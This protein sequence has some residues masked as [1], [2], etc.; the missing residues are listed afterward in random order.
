MISIQNLT[1]T[2]PNQSLPAIENIC[3]SVLDG[4]FV[5]V[6]GPSGSGKSTLLRTINGLVP[7]FSGGQI[8]GK[9]HVH[10][11]DVVHHGPQ[12]MSRYVGFVG[13]DPESQSVLD[14]VESEIAF[15]LENQ[16]VPV[17]EMRLRVEEVL[18]LL[19]LSPLR[20]RSITNLSGGE[21]QRVAIAVALAL[22]PS[23]LV[24]DEPTSQLDPQSAEDVLR[25]LVR[26]NEDL[27]LTIVLAEHRLERIIRYVD[28]ITHMEDGRIR[29]DA[30][31]Q[32]ALESIT[33]VPPIVQ[34]ARRLDWRPLPLTV[35][36]AKRFVTARM[37]ND[38][39][40][41]PNSADH[42][43]IRPSELPLLEI[44]D[45]S[46]SYNGHQTLNDVSL[47]VQPGEA[48]ALIGRNGAGKTT[49]LK[50]I[51]G[52]LTAR[53]GFISINGRPS[54]GREVADIC[55]EVGYLPQYPDDLLF[56]DTVHEELELTLRNHKQLWN[57]NSDQLISDLGLSDVIDQ[58]PR[59]LSVGQRQRV[60]LGAV[61][62]TRPRVVLLDEPTR[63]LD[64][65]TKENL[66][67]LWQSW[68]AEGI[69]LLLVTHDV[70]LVAMLAQRTYVLSQG[71]IITSGLTR[72]VLSSA[73]QFAPQIARLF[74]GRGWLTAAEALAGLSNNT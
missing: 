38:V 42:S 45:L 30:P 8:E 12:K 23:I 70:E 57:T 5:L 40:A 15:G 54:T 41:S 51:V 18:D 43:F 68:L 65:R 10:G 22:R 26:L 29:V 73:P 48:V 33:A 28:R 34:L 7:H 16:A 64:S 71:E 60:A 21:R 36:E 39:A 58:Y 1:Y 67:A 59:D 9:V 56:A 32:E 27:G 13:Q 2:Y 19:D 49:L 37:K 53:S 52:L 62:V 14:M 6:T 25:S 63:G 4:E 72:D 61:T 74:P 11:V 35:R 47:N 55:R 44:K 24:L 46:F 20:S 66:T 17:S 69:G 50:C 31:V 3:W